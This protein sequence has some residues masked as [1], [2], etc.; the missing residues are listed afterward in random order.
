MTRTGFRFAALTA[1]MCGVLSIAITAPR[2]LNAQG[3]TAASAA[4]PQ[5]VL[6][7]ITQVKPDMIPG[8][9]AAVQAEGIPAFKKAGL[10]WRHTYRTGPFG[11]VGLF[12]AVQPV[13]SMAQ[14]DQP[15]AVPRVLGQE[16]AARYAA[17]VRAMIV[18]QKQILQTLQP[19]MSIQSQSTEIAGLLVVEEIQLHPD[20]GAAFA[21]LIT[22]Q[23]IP[24]LKKAGV[25]DYWVFSDTWGGSLG[26]R[27][28]VEPIANYAGLEPG[29]AQGRLAR[30]LGA[31]A[32]QKINAQRNALIQ[33][34]DRTVLRLVPELSFTTQPVAKT[35][36]AR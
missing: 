2:I 21:E 24:A 30:V 10:P 26:S 27:T 6:V 36:S 18:S 7:T 25:K 3:Q 29:Q 13:T 15:G 5:R 31:Q 14:F 32:A 22:S 34:A 17:K 9:Q 4:A 23:M 1:V 12:V 11:D 20:K 33:H 35:T 28:I 8:Y 16:G 19:A